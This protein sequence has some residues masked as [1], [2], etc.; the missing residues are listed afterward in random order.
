[1]KQIEGEVGLLLGN[2]AGLAMEP[3][4]VVNSENGGPFAV[5]TMGLAGF[6]EKEAASQVVA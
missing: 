2:N 5:K 1:M 4:Q 6:L 3:L